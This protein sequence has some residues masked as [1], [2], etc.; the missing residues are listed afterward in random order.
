[1][2]LITE[3]GTGLATAESLCS[4]ADATAYHANIGN[5]AW[6]ALASDAIREQC[7]RKATLYMEGYYREK[8]AG[9]RKTSVQS[10]SWP[11]AWVPMKD[12][13]S[14]YGKFVAYYPTTI[15]PVQVVNACASLALRASAGDLAP[16]LDRETL[17]EGV[18]G[19][20]VTYRA[21]APQFVR[22]RE[23]DLML[24]PYLAPGGPVIVRA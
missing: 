22:F 13:P 7:L 17:S 8:Y 12:S 24:S 20:N 14:G 11:R 6:A 3:D 1:M 15:V 18:G 19:I 21:G 4:V 23:I 16:D 2:A 9:F 10:L 5:V